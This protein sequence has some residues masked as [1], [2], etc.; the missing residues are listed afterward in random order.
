LLP[1]I[2]GPSCLDRDL[3]SQAVS[4]DLGASQS[5]FG[6]ERSASVATQMAWKQ[7]FRGAFAKN[8]TLFL[9]AR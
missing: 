7:S 5:Q 1:V 2:H 9:P 6:Q 3:I 8:A 4:G